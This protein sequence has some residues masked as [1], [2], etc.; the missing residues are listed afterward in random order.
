MAR[1]TAPRRPEWLLRRSKVSGLTL[2]ETA[3]IVAL[4]GVLAIHL[5]ESHLT[6]WRVWEQ[7]QKIAGAVSDVWGI[8]DSARAWAG[9]NGEVWPNDQMAT[10][11]RIVIDQLLDDGYLRAF[12]ESQYA[13]CGYC[14]EYRQAGPRP[15][16]CYSITGWNLTASS[17]TTDPETADALVIKFSAWGQY[18]ADSIASQIPSGDAAQVSGDEFR[19]TALVPMRSGVRCIKSPV[20]RYV[21]LC[22][23]DRTVDFAEGDLQ[24][25]VDIAG[26]MPSE[27]DPDITGIELG[28]SELSAGVISGDGVARSLLLLRK[29]AD[30]QTNTLAA[31]GIASDLQRH[32]LM[33]FGV[34]ASCVSPYLTL[35]P[36]K[37]QEDFNTI[38]MESG[39]LFYETKDGPSLFHPPLWEIFLAKRSASVLHRGVHAR[40]CAL[41]RAIEGVSPDCACPDT[42]AVSCAVES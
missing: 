25:V 6:E 28:A 10:D 30:T 20:S 35:S 19:I 12:P 38:A 29:D 9:E 1:K 14:G 32:H 4:F 37:T 36:L 17:E 18:A 31:L 26:N 16:C 15:A 33:K 11:P 40:L 27:D 24:G 39:F 34:I 22:G 5:A 42:S 13:E 21:R 41:E 3:L 2:V 8:I 7:N 23:E